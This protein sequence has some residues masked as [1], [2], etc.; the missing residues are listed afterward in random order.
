[1]KISQ[2]A[3]RDARVAARRAADARKAGAAIDRLFVQARTETYYHGWSDG[4]AASEVHH[5]G[6]YGVATDRP[7]ANAESD[8]ARANSE[9]FYS[10]AAGD[11][12]DLY[13]D[14]ASRTIS[15]HYG[16]AVHCGA[17]AVSSER[18]C[19][20]DAGH[21]GDHFTTLAYGSTLTWAQHKSDSGAAS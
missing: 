9:P 13:G 16:V 5:N 1:V 12:G 14:T 2:D 7:G 3:A 21:D 15:P 6:H 4:Y 11:A 19:E 18:L 10:T 20:L 17:K 8:S